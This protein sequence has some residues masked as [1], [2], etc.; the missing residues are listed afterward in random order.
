MELRVFTEPQQGASYDDLLRVALTAEELGF[1]AFFRSD[2]YLAMGT[3][4]QP[5]P[6]DAWVTLAGLAR[7]AG[8]DVKVEVATPPHELPVAVDRAAYRIV[9]ESITNVIRHA[10]PARVTVEVAYESSD[11]RVRVADDGSGCDGAGGAGRGI[12]GMRERC[13]LLGGDL[14]A[15]PRAGS[16][17]EVS[18]RLPLRSA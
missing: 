12:E 18:A 10:G 4:G 17:F 14:T 3:D 13:A 2:H 11:L 5:G 9:Q 8:L 16:G 1:G 7:E 15:G 6:S